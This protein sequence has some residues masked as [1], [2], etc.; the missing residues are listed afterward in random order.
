[1][2][3]ATGEATLERAARLTIGLLEAIM[4]GRLPIDQGLQCIEAG[5][6]ATETIVHAELTL[7]VARFSAAPQPAPAPCDPTTPSRARP[8][9][10]RTAQE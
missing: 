7:E 8:T 9:W 4:A 2:S 1:V 6:R 3:E 5:R 10:L